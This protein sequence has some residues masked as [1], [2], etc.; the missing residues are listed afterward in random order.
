MEKVFSATL[1]GG[2]SSDVYFSLSLAELRDRI[3]SYGDN[4]IY[5]FD[6]NTRP[7]LDLDSARCLTLDSGEENK[8]YQ[9][10]DKIIRF[11]LSRGCARDTIF[12][13]IGGGVVCDMTAFAS[14]I[15]MR[16]ARVVLVPTTLLSMVDA[17]VGGKTGI[18]YM[19]Y[20]NLIGSFFPAEDILITLE[21]LKSLDEE[22]FVSGLGEVVKHAFLAKD[23]ELFNFLLNERESILSRELSSL[24]TVVR[25]SLDVKKYYIE[26]DPEERRGI[27]SFLNLGHTF[28]HALETCTNYAISHGKGVAWGLKRA[29]DVSLNLGLCSES[30]YGKALSLLSLYPFD[31]D[32]QLDVSMLPS[33]MEAI[34]KDKKRKDGSVKF[35]LV[36][37]QGELVLKPLTEAEILSVVVQS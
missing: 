19:G 20:K 21:C 30:Y 32:A 24:C 12:V 9:S 3:I 34:K 10:I 18:D 23:E 6:E 31:I 2:V 37:G 25:L 14:S 13:A 28:S 4:A 29:F 11:A 36:K 35:V 8:N 5:I 26:A 33:Y 1:S 17:S 15:F 22:Q 16:G 7:L 27:R